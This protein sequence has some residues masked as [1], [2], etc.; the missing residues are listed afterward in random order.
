LLTLCSPSTPFKA[1]ST[2]RFTLYAGCHSHAYNVGEYMQCNECSFC[3]NM[4]G[5]THP[6]INQH[7]FKWNGYNIMYCHT[8]LIFMSKLSSAIGANSVT[9]RVLECDVLQHKCSDW[10]NV[11]PS[12]TQP[13]LRRCVPRWGWLPSPR[14]QL[15][16][17]IGTKFQ[18]LPLCFRGQGIQ[19]Y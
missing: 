19:R 7:I 4:I 11:N 13:I 1:D 8:S 17:K 2:K 12:N 18:R 3:R 5:S 16:D 9:C 15:L 14:S 10:L 6:C